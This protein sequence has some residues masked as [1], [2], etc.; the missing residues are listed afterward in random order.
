MSI[1]Q[2]ACAMLTPLE[3]SVLKS[4]LA[5]WIHTQCPISSNIGGLTKGNRV[6]EENQPSQSQM[7]TPAV[8]DIS[9][10]AL[11][12]AVSR[13]TCLCGLLLRNGSPTILIID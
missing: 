13:P 6:E 1:E 12:L 10:R 9:P 4:V 11:S 8:S 7:Y 2:E 5:C 3:F